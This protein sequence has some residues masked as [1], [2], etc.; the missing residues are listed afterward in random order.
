MILKTKNP[1]SQPNPTQP[2]SIHFLKKPT[3]SNLTYLNWAELVSSFNTC[4][5]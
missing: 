2:N 1:P 4:N 5:G 3:Q